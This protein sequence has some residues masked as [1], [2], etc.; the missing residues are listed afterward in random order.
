V[1][2]AGGV[3]SVPAAGAGILAG[4][5]DSGGLLTALCISAGTDMPQAL[6]LPG[7]CAAGYECFFIRSCLV[8]FVPSV[9]KCRSGINNPGKTTRLIMLVEI[10]LVRLPAIPELLCGLLRR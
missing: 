7:K 1:D 4:M 5:R 9:R 3:L 10:L 6:M 2:L 8:Y